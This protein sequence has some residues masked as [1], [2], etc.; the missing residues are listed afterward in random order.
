MRKVLFIFGELSDTDVDW[1]AK[2][3]EK[4]HIPRGPC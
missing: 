2:A 1:L 4:V 3:G